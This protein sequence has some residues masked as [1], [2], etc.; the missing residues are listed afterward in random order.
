[1]C[2]ALS[3]LDLESGRW[4]LDNLFSQEGVVHPPYWMNAYSVWAIYLDGW[5]SCQWMIG[6]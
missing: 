3:E 2:Q 6:S 1:M 4:W 5:R